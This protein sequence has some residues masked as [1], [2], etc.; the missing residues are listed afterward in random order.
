MAT[1]A[2]RTSLP[3]TDNHEHIIRTLQ[4]FPTDSL[5]SIF[6]PFYSPPTISLLRAVILVVS[7]NPRVSQTRYLQYQQSLEAWAPCLERCR[8]GH[9][10]R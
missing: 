1:V 8:M 5:P 6:L 4:T 3:L 2:M 9:R 10:S 7:L